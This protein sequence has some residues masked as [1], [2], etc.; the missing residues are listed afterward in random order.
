MAAYN[1][2]ANR[3]LTSLLLKPAEEKKNTTAIIYN[4][5]ISLWDE[6]S[7]W[8]QRMKLFEKP[9]L[10]SKNF[11]GTTRDAIDGLM[12]QSALWEAWTGNVS[13]YMLDHVVQYIGDG[14]QPVKI[15]VCHLLT[16]VFTASISRRGELLA[17]LKQEGIEKIPVLDFA[18]FIRGRK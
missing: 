17:Y 11:K 3:R 1:A 7:L 4:Q 12:S 10:P 14:K 2:W 9:V 18:L 5:L 16:Q 6:E 15:Q 13:D 8:W